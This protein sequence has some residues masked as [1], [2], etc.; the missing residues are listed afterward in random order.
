[1][2]HHAEPE[3]HG[4]IH[5]LSEIGTQCLSG[6]HTDGMIA[7][8]KHTQGLCTYT[9]DCLEQRR[10][11]CNSKPLEPVGILCVMLIR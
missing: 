1:M 10:K 2:L 9:H 4:N 11:A 7:G 8:R 5:K 6:A 3:A